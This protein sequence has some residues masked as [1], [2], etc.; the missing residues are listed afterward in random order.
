MTHVHQEKLQ[1]EIMLDNIDLERFSALCKHHRFRLGQTQ[2]D[3]ARGLLSVSQYSKI[4]SGQSIPRLSTVKQLSHRLSFPIPLIRPLDY[5]T[6][7]FMNHVLSALVFDHTKM[8]ETFI[9]A[10]KGRFTSVH[11]VMLDLALPLLS[12]QPSAWV[13]ITMLDGF[14][15]NE[16]LH[17]EDGVLLRLLLLMHCEAH[18]RFHEA[19][20][21]YETYG[22]KAFENPLYHVLY[23]EQLYKLMTAH[24]RPVLAQQ[25]YQRA[26]ETAFEISA[27]RRY[28]FLKL[29]QIEH[30]SE[31]SQD[32]AIQHLR[33]IKKESL[34]PRNFNLYQVLTHRLLGEPIQVNA[35]PKLIDLKDR[36]YYRL[37]RL[38]AIQLNDFS[39]P[40]FDEVPTIALVEKAI[41]HYQ[42]AQ[43]VEDKLL[44]LKSFGLPMAQR[45][46]DHAALRFFMH[47]QIKHCQATKRYKEAASI[48]ARL[49]SLNHKKVHP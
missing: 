28:Q 39:T 35:T 16:T 10:H 22:L 38:E 44:S 20:H 45:Q 32:Q 30:L 24:Q 5:E 13:D 26:L 12:V 9:E 19:L 2:S 29:K 43:T 21:V 4:E 41:F 31:E 36:D 3:T 8:L 33:F 18:H 7:T 37:K 25:H 15:K 49:L 40:V 47:E 11:Q 6:Q 23:H 46:C 34:H 42:K 14:F 27:T 48:L 17:N 1:P